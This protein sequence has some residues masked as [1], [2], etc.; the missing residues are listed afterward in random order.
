[1]TQDTSIDDEWLRWIEIQKLATKEW[2]QEDNV[3]GAIEILDRYL[4]SGAG[5]GCGDLNREAIAFR[6]TLKEDCGDL[7]AAKKD[8]MAALVLAP[9]PDHVR[10]ELED[11]IAG[12]SVK[13]GDLE[14]A[15]RWFSAALQS[16]AEDPR[17]AG[18][19][20]LIR[21]IR[22]RGQK[23]LTREE[24]G[25]TKKIIHQSWSLLRVEGEP[26]LNDLM[27]TCARLVEAR[28]GPF[29]AERPPA[30]KAYSEQ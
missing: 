29:S 10:F 2:F 22:F 11:S 12:L 15:D 25:L 4:A 14:D 30:P 23:G 1:M 13:L 7:A 21:F 9:E 19:G 3:A 18:G 17:V 16:A 27:A 24:L 20:F 6:G 28:K 5:D 26:D 8:F